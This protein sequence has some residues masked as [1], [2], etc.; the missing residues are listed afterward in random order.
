MENILVVIRKN[1]L[2]SILDNI[3]DCTSIELNLDSLSKEEN[4]NWTKILDKDFQPCGCDTGYYFVLT[5]LIISTLY[6]IINYSKILNESLKIFGNILFFVF[7]MGFMGKIIG[8]IF[9]KYRL[10]NNIENLKRKLDTIKYS[11]Q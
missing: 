4:E 2:E 3:S 7:V 9:S 6:L 8:I 5:S 1:D 11:H 10:R